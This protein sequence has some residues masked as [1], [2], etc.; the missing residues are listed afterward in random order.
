MNHLNRKFTDVGRFIATT[1]EEQHWHEDY[2]IE[3]VSEGEGVHRINTKEYPV[4]RGLMY[5]IRLR[6][7]HQFTITSPTIVHRITLPV[8]CMPE[9][10]VRSMLKSPINLVTQLDEEATKHIEGLFE[11]LESR[12][13]P[14]SEE[15]LYIQ[16]CLL[17][18][19]IML[20]TKAVNMNPCDTYRST[21]GKVY[22]TL[23]YIEDNF[24]EKLSLESVAAHFDM[25]PTYLNRIV[26]EETGL[27]IYNAIKLTR[28]GY[29]A[30]LCRETDMLCKD[31]CNTCGYS[32]DANFQ[33]DFKNHFGVTPL[34]YRKLDRKGILD[35]KGNVLD[36]YLKV[37]GNDQQN[38]T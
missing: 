21:K 12:P 32:G 15:E 14:E 30:K 4:K 18:V 17:N 13:K 19:L 24:R 10:Y 27:T 26:K 20:F 37:D 33:R 2:Q 16:D 38:D 28:L 25:N 31:I 6:D 7:Y 9:R 35:E 36:K 22:D 23:L 11:L 1:D 8:K 3:F 34:Q 29:A 5:A